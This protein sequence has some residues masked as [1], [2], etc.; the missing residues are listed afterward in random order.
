MRGAG[1]LLAAVVL[2][3]AAPAG[4]QAPGYRSAASRILAEGRAAS[5]LIAHGSSGR[6]YA[7]FT[8]QFRAQVSL[9]QLTQTIGATLSAFRFS[10]SSSGIHVERLLLP[11]AVR[12]PAPRDACSP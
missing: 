11:L 6:L 8:P 3:V 7:K 12:L 5:A 4:A 1:L 10:G 9:P 2:A